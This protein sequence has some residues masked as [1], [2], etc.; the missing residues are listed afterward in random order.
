[1]KI[2]KMMVE[3]YAAVRDKSNDRYASSEDEMNFNEQQARTCAGQD[4]IHRSD[5]MGW[6]NR[7]QNKN[8]I[9]TPSSGDGTG[10]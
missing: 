9:I 2:D 1:M 8:I 10:S 5:N 3:G 6:V 4:Q 7:N